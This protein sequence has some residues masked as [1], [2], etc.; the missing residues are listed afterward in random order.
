MYIRLFGFSF[1]LSL[2]EC[3]LGMVCVCAPYVTGQAAGKWC[4]AALGLLLSDPARSQP[5]M[6]TLWM[7][8]LSLQGVRPLMPPCGEVFRKSFPFFLKAHRRAFYSNL[9]CVIGL[10]VLGT[11]QL[12][13]TLYVNIR[14]ALETLKVS[15]ADS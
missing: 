10:I 3:C 15:G 13:S 14:Y 4:V 2:Q 6:P 11:R 9:K 1:S 8:L 7:E 12:I 5:W